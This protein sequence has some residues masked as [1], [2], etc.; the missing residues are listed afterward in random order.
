MPDRLVQ[1]QAGIV[2]QG[3][4]VDL[5]VDVGDVANI[6]HLLRAIDM[7]QQPEQDIEDDDRTGVADMGIVVDGRAADIHA[8]IVGIDRPEIDL[9]PRQRVVQL[10]CRHSAH[11]KS[12]IC[13]R[14]SEM[15]RPGGPRVCHLGFRET[16]TARPA[17]R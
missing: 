5:V 14:P 15:R 7:A 3:A 11:S 1:R 16:K 13:M 9:L 2:A 17:K 10:K 8:D 6:G 4:R 12:P